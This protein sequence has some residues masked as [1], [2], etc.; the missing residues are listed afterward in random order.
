M[1]RGKLLTA[2]VL[3]VLLGPAM[4]K[5]DTIPGGYVS[6]TWYQANSPYYI[7]GGIAIPASDTLIIEPGVDVDFQGNYTF[8]VVG[9]LDAIGTE[10]DS[11]HFTS[12]GNWKGIIFDQAPDSSHL[13]YCTVTHVYKPGADDGAIACEQSS[14][15]ISHC[16]ISNNQASGISC[17]MLSSPTVTACTICGDTSDQGGGIY[18]AGFS[19]PIFRNCTISDNY[20]RQGGGI[21]GFNRCDITLDECTISFNYCSTSEP[22][23]GGGICAIY[24][25]D[26]SLHRCLILGN[27]ADYGGGAYLEGGNTDLDHCT[28]SGNG[29]AFCDGTA[30]YLFGS[31]MTLSNSIVEGNFGFETI[32][33]VSGGSAI[34]TYCD[35]YNNGGTPLYGCPI[36]GLCQQGQTNANGDP[37]GFSNNISLDPLFVG[38]GDYHLTEYSPCIDAGDT[39]FAYDPD[40]TITDM[41]RYS[42]DHRLANIE[43]SD[44]LLDFDTVTV[45]EQGDLPLTIYNVG[46]VDTLIVYDIS[47]GFAV[48]CTDFDPADSLILPGDSLKLTVS[49]SPS[50]TT[51]VLDTLR[52]TDNDQ[53]CEVELA[54]KG[55]EFSWVDEDISAERPREYALRPAYPNPFNPVTTIGFDLPKASEVTL[56]ICNVLGQEVGAF[57]LGRLPAGKYDYVWRADGLAGGV[58]F[59]RIEAGEFVQTRKMVMV[60]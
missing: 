43:I 60:K 6:G 27:E 21:F 30:F 10:T 12:S 51:T 38:G 57:D 48:F 39:L 45:D 7:T 22:I 49:F 20:A 40:S 54:G 9:Y 41:G 23:G 31:T 13:S 44:S 15:A 4:L 29:N 35:F 37:C 46:T 59:Y 42:F 8:T 5:A 17:I 16:T 47:C 56:R 26:L 2:I 55:S 24:Q 50:D 14:P 32:R 18:V 52:I 34:I 25:T 53:L 58:Y 3:I 36:P 11:I 28:I 1:L 19:Y 33:Y